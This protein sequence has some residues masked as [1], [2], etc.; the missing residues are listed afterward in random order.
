[1]SLLNFFFFPSF[2]SLLTSWTPFVSA[3]A[4]IFDWATAIYKSMPGAMVPS[5]VTLSP[6]LYS[7]ADIFASAIELPGTAIVMAT[8][9]SNTLTNGNNF[10]ICPSF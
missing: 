9:K 2:L 7:D 3:G 5:M 10:F 4:N 6:A 8:A 1:M